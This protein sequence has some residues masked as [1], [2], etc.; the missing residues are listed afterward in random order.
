[1]AVTWQFVDSI[2]SSPTV[3]LDLN[4]RNPFKVASWNA[5]PPPKNRSG[6]SSSARDGTNVAQESFSDREIT[7]TVNIHS[8][9]QD[10][11]ATA[12]QA[13]GR[14]LNAGQWLKFNPG[15]TNPV[16]FRTKPAEIDQLNDFNF[17]TDGFRTATLTIPAEPF[18]Y[19]LPESG[20]ATIAN[21]PT[22]GTN[23]MSYVFPTVKGDVATPLWL[24]VP[25]ASG[26]ESQPVFASVATTSVL[27]QSYYLDAS[28]GSIPAAAGGWTSTNP[29]DSAWVG[30]S[31]RR[32]VKTA[33]IAAQTMV[34]ASTVA[35]PAGDYRVF[36]RALATVD[37]YLRLVDSNSLSSF[38][39]VIPATAAA[40]WFDWG[41]C[42]FPFGAPPSGD[43]Y[44]LVPAMSNSLSVVVGPAASLATTGQIDLD[45]L[46]LVP[47]GL[48]AQASS[49]FIRVLVRN[50]SASAVSLNMD[51]V[52]DLVSLY[53]TSGPPYNT[54]GG[55]LSIDGAGFPEVVPG[56]S[57]LLTVLRRTHNPASTVDDDKTITTA[58]S[59]LYYP[60]YLYVRP[61]T[62]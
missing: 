40:R 21:D 4:D 55:S 38:A 42:R 37:M 26:E 7:L 14:L 17:S 51:G 18:A 50:P 33:G 31:K 53:G 59:W 47:A 19:G 27:S 22:A 1:M 3:L 5:P 23:P 43:P 39:S 11:S 34:A 54:A 29:T 41:V 58:L 16:F 35:I 9:S 56:K 62:T 46:L 44:G 36:V 61:A 8:T 60:R 28:G 15:T 52:N 6:T 20:S 2:A 25:L 49:K 32:A 24:S 13:L 10:G 12:I 57:N 30:G 45:G 48:D